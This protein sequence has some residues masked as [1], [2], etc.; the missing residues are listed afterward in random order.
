MRDRI[1]LASRLPSCPAR[2]QRFSRRSFDFEKARI[3]THFEWQP[4][5]NAFPKLLRLAAEHD[6]TIA[7]FHQLGWT[8]AGCAAAW[9]TA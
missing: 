5:S 3:I 1:G 2:A 6:P 8:I 7:R 9:L 4:F